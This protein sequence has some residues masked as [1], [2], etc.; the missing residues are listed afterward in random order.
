M[1]ERLITMNQSSTAAD[2]GATP[3]TAPGIDTSYRYIEVGGGILVFLGLLAVLFPFVTGVS[4]S[5]LLGSLL[6]VGGLV[7]VAHAFRAPG[8]GGFTGQ[9]LL[10]LV[11]AFAGISLLANPV[12]GL[13]TLTVLVITY[14]LVSGI[15]QAITGFQLRGEPNW[16]WMVMSGSISILLAVLLWLGLPATAAW[17][18][19]LLFGANLVTTGLSMLML[20]FGA[21]QATTTESGQAEGAGT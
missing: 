13:V 12:L 18:V 1:G 4:L 19:G 16:V 8:W 9:V 20:G 7:H 2:D 15:V 17:A 6:V 21:E 14:F 10:A 3:S 11:Y 5:I